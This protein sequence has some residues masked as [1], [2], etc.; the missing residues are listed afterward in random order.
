MSLTNQDAILIES[1]DSM[2]VEMT[3]NEF[4]IYIIKVIHEGKDKTANAGN[5]WSLQYTVKIANA[6]RKREL[7]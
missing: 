4:R 1:N 6:G 2:A 5:V 3:E 7:Q